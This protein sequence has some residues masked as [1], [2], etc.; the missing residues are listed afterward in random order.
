VSNVKD[1]ALVEK[2]LSETEPDDDYV[3]KGSP[4]P[5]RRSASRNTAPPLGKRLPVTAQA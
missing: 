3:R 1:N 2:I 4:T 5:N